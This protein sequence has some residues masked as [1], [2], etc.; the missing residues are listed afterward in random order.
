NDRLASTVQFLRL[1]GGDDRHGSPALRDE[2]VRQTLEETR[3][4]DFREAIETRPARRALGL[5]AGSLVLLLAAVL[6]DPALARIAARRLFLPFGPDRWPQQTHL[7][8]IDKETPRKVARG[9]PFT[10]A[11]AVRKGERAPSSARA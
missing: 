7:A 8:L 9:E 6:A 11:V 2:T 5:A 10:L 1:A 3:A 4:I